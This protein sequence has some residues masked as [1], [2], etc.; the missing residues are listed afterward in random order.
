MFQE[1]GRSRFSGRPP[2]VRER[3]RPR[4]QGAADRADH[5]SDR[6]REGAPTLDWPPERTPCWCD[7]GR[8]YK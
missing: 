6:V 2:Q 4:P 5:L 8:K 3:P 1:A 7:S